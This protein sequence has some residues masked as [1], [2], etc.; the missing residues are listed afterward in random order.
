MYYFCNFMEKE[1]NRY[2]KKGVGAVRV[3][4]DLDSVVQLAECYE[5]EENGLKHLDFL[6]VNETSNGTKIDFLGK[7]SSDKLGCTEQE[8]VS[9]DENPIII[10][11][12]KKFK[13][14]SGI[15]TYIKYLPIK[16]G[17]LVA[18]IKGFISVESKDGQM[19]PLSRNCDATLTGTSFTYNA[20]DIRKLNVIKEKESDIL[21]SDYVVNDCIISHTVTKD[22]GS[23]KSVKFNKDNFVILNKEVFEEAKE[24]KIAELK[25]KEEEK[26]RR[27]EEIARFNAEYKKRMLE[28]ENKKAEAKKTVKRNSTPK[29]ETVVAGSEGAQFFLNC[30]AQMK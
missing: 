29:K 20:D 24:R 27:D 22:G 2:S 10:V 4:N 23:L 6:T 17:A 26:K 11:A 25:A 19:L 7:F 13:I 16:G 5:V 3:S 28:E 18:L 1:L 30:V 12:T 15:P 21:Y 8:L 9:T 14:F